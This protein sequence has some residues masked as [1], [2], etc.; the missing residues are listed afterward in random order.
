MVYNLILFNQ[1]EAGIR[2]KLTGYTASN[3]PTANLRNICY[4]Y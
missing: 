1:T 4:E 3:Y 2:E